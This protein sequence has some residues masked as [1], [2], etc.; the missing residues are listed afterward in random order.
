[1]TKTYGDHNDA[2][3]FGDDLEF[4]NDGGFDSHVWAWKAHKRWDWEIEA[5]AG[6]DPVIP[7]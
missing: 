7:F 2:D 3:R 6:G 5:A 4:Y 1:M